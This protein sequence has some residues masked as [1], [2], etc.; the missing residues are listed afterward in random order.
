[1]IRLQHGRNMDKMTLSGKRLMRMSCLHRYMTMASKLLYFWGW[2]IWEQSV[3]TV[4]SII[5]KNKKSKGAANQRLLTAWK[6]MFASIS[7]WK[8]IDSL[9]YWW[10]STINH[11]KYLSVKVLDEHNTPE[12]W[13]SVTSH[14]LKSTLDYHHICILMMGWESVTEFH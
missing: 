10:T 12:V 1:M 13:Q 9:P 6:E 8:N 2:H 5:R 4:T 7:S 14:T 11:R 3:Y